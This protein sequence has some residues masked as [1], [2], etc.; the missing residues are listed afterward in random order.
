MSDDNSKRDRRSTRLSISIPVVISGVDADGNVFNEGVRT[1]IVN[2][3]GGKVAATHHLSMG[4]EILIENRALGVVAKATVAWLGGKRYPG[5]L[6]HVGLQLLEAQ[7]VWGIV[8]PP[9]DWSLESWEEAPPAPDDPPAS[10]RA[11][12]VSAETRVSSLA[13]EEFTI[14]LLQELRESA[15]AHVREFQD[16]LNQLTQRLGLELEFDMRERSAQSSA[17]DISTLEEEIKV[18]REGLSAASERIEKLEAKILELQGGRQATA[19]IPPSPPAPLQEAQRQLTALTTS[20]M[21]SMNRAAKAG[22]DEYRS[23]LQK[24]NQ[25]SAARRRAR[26]QENPPPGGPTPET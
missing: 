14:R 8:F 22:L 10:E 23:L 9:D 7:N 19:E 18:L 3:H 6:H 25:Q 5:D 4:S 11:D 1:L 12:A 15:D 20:V 21:E 17:R 16:R 26:P 24:E 2:K 13:G